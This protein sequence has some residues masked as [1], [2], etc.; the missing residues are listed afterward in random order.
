VRDRRDIE[1]TEMLEMTAGERSR[2]L[3]FLVKVFTAFFNATVLI[4][5]Q[6]RNNTK[7]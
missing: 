2:N 1:L 6:D 5:L 7:L 3:L 4:L